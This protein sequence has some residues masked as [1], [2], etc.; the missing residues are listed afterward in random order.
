MPPARTEPNPWL[1][2]SRA[3]ASLTRRVGSGRRWGVGG[4]GGAVEVSGQVL[5][6][7]INGGDRVFHFNK[8]VLHLRLVVRDLGLQVGDAR[9]D[10]R[11][12]FGQ[13]LFASR[14]DSTAVQRVLKVAA[15]RG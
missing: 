6:G 1:H 4:R 5:L 7:N 8:L 2:A 12:L 14:N 9:G 11:G 15:D 3:A 10:V 13:T